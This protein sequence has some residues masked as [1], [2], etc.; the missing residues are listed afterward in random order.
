MIL[1]GCSAFG[2]WLPHFLSSLRAHDRT[3]ADC[4]HSGGHHNGVLLA[5][6][7]GQH[8]AQTVAGRQL[9][10]ARNR[11][12]PTLHGALL[13]STGWQWQWQWQWWRRWRWRSGG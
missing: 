4:S 13:V 7:L 11:Q 6:L 5:R 2:S 8:R 12:D 9:Q 3:A 10:S 1:N